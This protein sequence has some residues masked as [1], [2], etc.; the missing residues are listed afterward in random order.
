MRLIFDGQ[1]LTDGRTLNN[2]DI[3]YESTLHLVLRLRGGGS[4]LVHEMSVAAGGK[5]HQ[6]IEEDSLE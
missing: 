6:V 5:I 1:Q 4:I 3:V 2:Y